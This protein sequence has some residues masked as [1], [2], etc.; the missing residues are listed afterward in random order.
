[1][2]IILDLDGTLFDTTAR[3]ARCRK[4]GRM[5]WECW[6]N[7]I[8]LM[9]DRVNNDV[10]EFAKRLNEPVIIVSGR[11]RELQEEATIVQL[12]G[13]GLNINGIYLKPKAWQFVKEHAYK[14]WMIIHL[15]THGILINHVID[16]NPKVLDTAYAVLEEFG[17]PRPRL[18]LVKNGR[19][20][21]Y[22][23]ASR[24]IG[25]I[26]LDNGVKGLKAGC[27]IE[28]IL[29]IVKSGD[30]Y[31]ALCID[32]GVEL[33]PT[34]IDVLTAIVNGGNWVSPIV[35]PPGGP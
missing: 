6:F 23:P 11:I 28:Y 2:P 3:E 14:A 16:D 32:N 10:L 26:G 13:L 30:A 33:R 5:D 8:N 15:S 17:Q 24:P 29:R 25:W 35:Q 20:V 19:P 31:Y 12:T 1:M 18:W 27:G 22:E 4:G 9:L 21:E 34:G 7:P